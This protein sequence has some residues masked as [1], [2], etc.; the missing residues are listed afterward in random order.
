MEKSRNLGPLLIILVV[1]LVALGAYV[2]REDKWGEVFSKVGLV[3]EDSFQLKSVA[4]DGE[5]VEGFPEYLLGVVQDAKVVESA[6]YTDK[7][8]ESRIKMVAIYETEAGI[9]DM[10]AA[11][12]TY[13]TDRGFNISQALSQRGETRIGAT[14]GELNVEIKMYTKVYKVNIVEI[15]ALTDVL[16]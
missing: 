6:I 3:K 2:Q 14:A 10:F 9:P 5:A 7:E 12:L 13:L 1:L 4:R 11:Y 16:E 15:E 8:D